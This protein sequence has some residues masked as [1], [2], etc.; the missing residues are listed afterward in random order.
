M[1]IG[2]GFNK[3]SREVLL[4]IGRLAGREVDLKLGVHEINRGLGYDRTEIKNI[5]EHLQELGYIKIL[6][7]GGPLLYGHVTLT[8]EG[9]KKCGEIN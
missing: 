4:E 3:K 7:I 5:L 8:G 9:V 2:S 1:I 6:T